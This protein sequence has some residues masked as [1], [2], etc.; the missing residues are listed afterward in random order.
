MIP[1][2]TMNRSLIPCDRRHSVVFRFSL[3]AMPLISVALVTGCGG[4]AAFFRAN[5][6]EMKVRQSES[7]PITAEQQR[8]IANVLLALFGDP[9]DPDVFD[10]EEQL[11]GQSPLERFGFDL[12]KLRLAAGP[13]YSDELGNQHGLYRL[14]CAHCHGVTGDGKGPTAPFL[15]PYPRDYRQGIFKF[16]STFGDA[17]PTDHDLRQILLDGIPGTAMPSFKLLPDNEIDAL[18]EYVK[19]LS[20]RGET[21]I[22]LIEYVADEGELPEG[23][24]NTI[25]GGLPLERDEDGIPVEEPDYDDIVAPGTSIWSTAPPK[26]IHPVTPEVD[27]TDPGQLAASIERGRELFYSQK[28]KCNSCHGDS[29]LGDG[30]T[31]DYSAWFQWRKQMDQSQ[32]PPDVVAEKV[33]DFMEVGALRPRTIIPRNLRLGIY[34]GGRRPIDIYRRVFSG[35][36]GSP[37]P[38]QGAEGGIAGDEVPDDQAGGSIPRQAI[39][40]I[41]NYVLTLEDQQLSRSVEAVE[42]FQY[43]LR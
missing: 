28:V 14:H 39:W 15:N 8:D 43:N 26:G 19:Y 1:T 23:G 35:I 20:V 4:E 32:D 21:E 27:V 12:D 2:P 38:G 41:V 13:V 22:R 17:K 37:M 30:E 36:Y 16:K 24:I 10:Q 29:A 31:T 11:D 5:L 40:D 9:N 25:A 3:F 7:E 42:G 34:R 33:E 18:V 6:V